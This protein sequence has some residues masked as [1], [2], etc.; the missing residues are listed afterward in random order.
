MLLSEVVNHLKK[1][2]VP[3]AD[4]INARIE[5]LLEREFLVRDH[6]ELVYFT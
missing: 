5:L 4:V 3:T 2:F 6:E 1:R